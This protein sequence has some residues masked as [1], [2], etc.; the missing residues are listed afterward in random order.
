MKI[1]IPTLVVTTAI[2]FAAGVASAADVN[3][4]WKKECVSCHAKDGSG[5]TVMGKKSGAKDY[6]DPKVQADL[7]DAKAVDRIK[8]GFTENGKEKMKPFK[9]KVTDDEIKA[10]IAYI[11]T[12]KK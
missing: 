9:D 8:N 1:T 7:T 11:R 5:S 6:R 3:E 12:F 2:V 4:I 10:L